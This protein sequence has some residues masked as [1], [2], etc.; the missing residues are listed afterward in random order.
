MKKKNDEKKYHLYSFQIE[1]Y[2]FFCNKI[3]VKQ[4]EKL[5]ES[6]IQNYRN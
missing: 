2:I 5:N 3:F 1:I 4:F 6:G